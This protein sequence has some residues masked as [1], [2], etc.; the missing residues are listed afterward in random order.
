MVVG[1]ERRKQVR[2]L[3]GGTHRTWSS[4]GLR[5]KKGPECWQSFLFSVWKDS[6]AV[7][8][9]M[10]G[11]SGGVPFWGTLSLKHLWP[12]QGEMLS[13]Q[14]GIFKSRA[15]GHSCPYQEHSPNPG[16]GKRVS[17]RPCMS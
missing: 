14:L 16:E 7:Y 10:E 3:R 17:Q 2:D 9:S 13:R 1:V 6:H 15:E 11:L 5:E 12:I 8:S 4:S